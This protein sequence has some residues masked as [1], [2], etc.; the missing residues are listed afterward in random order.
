MESETEGWRVRIILLSIHRV[1]WLG[2]KGMGRM[3]GFNG[4]AFLSMARASSGMAMDTIQDDS[5]LLY[6]F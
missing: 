5:T 2:S 1:N 4:V 3:E 6:Y